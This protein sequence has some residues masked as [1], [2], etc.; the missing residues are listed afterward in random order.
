M[1]AVLIGLTA[2]QVACGGASAL[3]E[4]EITATLALIRVSTGSPAA[5]AAESAPRPGEAAHLD[6]VRHPRQGLVRPSGSRLV[7]V[8]FASVPRAKASTE[9]QRKIHVAFDGGV[10]TPIT[11]SVDAPIFAEIDLPSARLY[12]RGRFFVLAGA[13]CRQDAGALADAFAIRTPT[14]TDRSIEVA[15]LSGNLDTR[16][17]AVALTEAWTATATALV[18][19]IAYAVR[20]GPATRLGNESL[21]I[22]MPA[23]DHLATAPASAIAHA[24]PFTRVALPVAKGSSAGMIAT[25]GTPTL[26]AWTADHE[27]LGMPVVTSSQISMTVDITWPSGS[28]S[29]SLTATIAPHD[30]PGRVF[31][32]ALAL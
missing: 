27:P 14:W 16:G 30:E 20:K 8:D 15:W 2:M 32:D 13:P 3:T 29:P 28:A 22:V 25:F 24:G 4:S 19:G 26:Q 10:E 31:A 9:A 18:P 11:V 7:S 12:T 23:V 6:F 5:T 17:C 21:W 1:R